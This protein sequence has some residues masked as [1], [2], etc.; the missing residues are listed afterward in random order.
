MDDQLLE[1]PLSKWLVVPA[2]GAGL[3]MFF[4]A[5][6]VVSFVRAEAFGFSFAILF[7]VA[8][9]LWPLRRNDVLK[10]FFAIAVVATV[11]AIFLIPW[12][13]HHSFE[14][15]D[16]PFV[17]AYFLVLFGGAI[18]TDKVTAILDRRRNGS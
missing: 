16:L 18:L 8:V 1:A 14:K 3:A 13:E 6:R 15:S 12:P 17:S 7:V 5:S 4:I 9:A 11:A 10:A 2:I